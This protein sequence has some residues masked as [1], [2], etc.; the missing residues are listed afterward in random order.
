MIKPLNSVNDFTNAPSQNEANSTRNNQSMNTPEIEDSANNS[1]LK[2]PQTV[3]P[4][5]IKANNTQKAAEEETP[6]DEKSK[7]KQSIIIT[8][9]DVLIEY[10]NRIIIGL[11]K[12]SSAEKHPEIESVIELFIGYYVWH[13]PDLKV[14]KPTSLLWQRLEARLN[15]M[16]DR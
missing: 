1:K 11:K 2:R 4:A 8:G 13:T 12:L 3:N 15:E 9:D 14:S 7:G 6:K 16:K 5:S 10:V